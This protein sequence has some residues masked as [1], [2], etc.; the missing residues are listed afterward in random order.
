MHPGVQI[1]TRGTRY[2]A[3]RTKLMQIIKGLTEMA[4]P[5]GVT[6]DSTP[7]TI[8]NISLASG[9]LYLGPEQE[10]DFKNFTANFVVT[11]S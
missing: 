5:R 2:A 10:T 6:V 7:Y 8:A 4:V 9:P 3:T 1:R 11:F